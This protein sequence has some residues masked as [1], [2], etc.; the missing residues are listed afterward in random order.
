MPKQTRAEF[1]GTA[2]DAY[3]Q[4]LANGSNAK[5]AHHKA[6]TDLTSRFS[7]S[8]RVDAQHLAD[9]AIKSFASHS[10]DKAPGDAKAAAIRD[11]TQPQEVGLNVRDYAR[12]VADSYNR[13]Q[14]Q[15]KAVVAAYAAAAADAGRADIR[16]A[17]RV[18]DQTLKRYSELRQGGTD[19]SAAR[20][21]TAKE[22]S[23][24]F[25][26]RGRDTQRQERQKSYGMSL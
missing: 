5:E 21:Q 20:E 16:N 22:M 9:R 12:D 13:R 14:G 17:A 11:T 26:E 4:G 1:A 10:I 15:G 7:Q 23:R 6:V 19:H 18:A 8:S 24:R 2:I 3:Q 25:D